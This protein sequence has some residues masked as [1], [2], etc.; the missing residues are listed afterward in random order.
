MGPSL[1]PQRQWEGVGGEK[2]ATE[3]FRPGAWGETEPPKANEGERRD[4]GKTHPSTR[5]GVRVEW[6]CEGRQTEDQK[7]AGGGKSV[8][9]AERDREG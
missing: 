9:E 3:A 8:R 2:A 6:V 7:T 1:G 5:H 4:H